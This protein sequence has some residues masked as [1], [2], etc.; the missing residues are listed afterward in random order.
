M[1][2]RFSAVIAVFLLSIGLTARCYAISGSQNTEI[3]SVL[4]EACR[5]FNTPAMS[6]SINYKGETYY[7]SS[8]YANLKTKKAAD[9][10][11][12]YELASLSKAFTAMGILLL[13]EQGL[14]STDDSVNMYLPQLAFSYNG[15][16]VDMSKITLNNLIHHTSGITNISHM[17]DAY[18]GSESFDLTEA[19][20]AFKNA[21]LDFPSGE[22]MEYG[23]MNYNF[24]ALIIQNVSGQN[25]ED[26]IKENIFE[27]LGLHN[28]YI[29]RKAAANTG[30]FA[31]GYRPFFFGVTPYDYNTQSGGNVGDSGVISSVKDMARWLKI[32]SGEIA[33]IPEIYKQVIEKSHIP[34]AIESSADYPYPYAAGWDV[35]NDG[36]YIYHLGNCPS[37]VTYAGFYPKEQVGICLLANSASANADI[38]YEI[39]AVLDGE[40]YEGE[41][42]ITFWQDIDKTMSC[43]A[44]IAG[45]AAVVFI[46]LAVRGR[47]LHKNKTLSKLRLALTAFC[48]VITVAVGVIGLILPKFFG[49][50][51]WLVLF[52]WAPLSVPIA[53]V[54]TFLFCASVTGFVFAKR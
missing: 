54:A 13:Q 11:T 20:E 23:T 48:L 36:A 34:D 27:P 42:P 37:F 30:N 41:V 2:K 22:K 21:N 1:I 35:K 12:L 52:V 17:A 25:F 50:Y 8:G 26:Y 51:N 47:K 10:N 49:D 38:V 39:K 9:E 40:N 7:F 15:E 19:V 43:V 29:D 33:D 31:Q 5:K 44:I 4:D 18:N 53:V 45:L 28:T 3:Q 46:I 24:L 16:K 32:Q 6:L 14:L